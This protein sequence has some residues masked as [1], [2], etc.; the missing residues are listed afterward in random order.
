MSDAP[1][2][3]G[4][5]QASDGKWYPPEQA[6]AGSTPPPGPGAPGQ[7]PPGAGM[8]PPGGTFA[9]SGGGNLSVGDAISYGFSK[10]GEYIGQIVVILAVLLVVNLVLQF[11]R[12]SIDNIILGTV[13]AIVGWIVSL[14]IQL[15]LVRIALDVT[16]GRTPDIANV[17]KTDR[18]TP[19]IIASI[20]Y[21]LAI[22]VGLFLLCIGAI[23]AAFIF[24]F[25]PFFILDRNEEPVQSLSSSFNLVKQE[26]GTLIL[27]ALVAIVLSG[28]SCGILAPVG[29]FAAAYAY[30]TLNGETVAA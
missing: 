3:P 30:R 13:L 6:P 20:L 7:V 27:L 5:W 24:Y 26:P 28:I 12:L 8:T 25:Y 16:A 15:G 29:W 19:Y 18:L 4:W 11:L 22:F 14:V 10:F 21:G 23:V 17:F 2:G 1:Q 9:A